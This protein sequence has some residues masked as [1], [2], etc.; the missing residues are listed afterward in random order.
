MF[1]VNNECSTLKQVIVGLGAPYHPDKMLAAG[2]QSEYTFIP[3]TDRKQAVLA[4]EYPD[5]ALLLKEFRGFVAILRQFHVEVLFANPGAA[6]SID[7]TCPRDIGF[8]IGQQFFVAN[9]AVS[10]RS[11]EYQTIEPLIQQLQFV[12]PLRPPDGALLEGG[13]IVLLDRTTV[14]VGYNQRSN[15]AGAEYLQRLLAREGI[16]VIPVKHRQLHLDCC[17]NPLGM[18]HLLIHPD[19]LD[20]NPDATWSLLEQFQWIKV[21]SIEREHLATNVLSIDPQTLI[22]RDHP[23]CSRI[24]RSIERLGYS[25][26]TTSFDGVPATGGSFRCASLPLQR[27]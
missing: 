12:P 11:D 13:D 26:I 8:V 3:E 19:S 18:G 1:N 22:A 24:N 10:S 2:H 4:L 21:N 16:T 15:L 25:V 7:Y 9:M 14:L 27:A 23:A 5:E 17:L 20:G 6:Y